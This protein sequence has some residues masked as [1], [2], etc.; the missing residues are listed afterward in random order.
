MKK[1]KGTLL[2]LML[3][4]MFSFI[5]AKAFA[6]PMQY[7][8]T[9]CD[10]VGYGRKTSGPYVYAVQMMLYSSGYGPVIWGIDGSFGPKTNEAVKTF[11]MAAGLTGDG[12]VG[13]NTWR[14]FQSH[15]RL[16]SIG[17][18]SDYNFYEYLEYDDEGY[19]MDYKTF[20]NAYDYQTKWYVYTSNPA[21]TNKY[22]VQ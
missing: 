18:G 17:A 21:N 1:M 6:A 8:W 20:Y 7:D 19:L 13:P 12:I 5:P 3:V 14:V 2:F 22:Y 15:R 4:T 9:K 11:Q 10:S 16:I